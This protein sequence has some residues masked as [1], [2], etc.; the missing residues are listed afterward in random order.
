MQDVIKIMDIMY[1]D[2]PVELALWERPPN[3]TF[4]DRKFLIESV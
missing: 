2:Y 1:S 4:T 3:K